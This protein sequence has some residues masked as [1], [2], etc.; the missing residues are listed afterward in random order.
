MEL[1]FV[2]TFLLSIDVISLKCGKFMSLKYQFC[3]VTP[4]AVS[5]GLGSHSGLIYPYIFAPHF[6][7]TNEAVGKG[8]ELPELHR[9]AHGA[10]TVLSTVF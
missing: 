8:R 4:D 10:N 1:F 9:A 5:C 2:F 7:L 6:F 3:C